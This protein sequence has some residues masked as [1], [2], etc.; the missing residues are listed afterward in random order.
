MTA[1]VNSTAYTETKDDSSLS[2]TGGLND[3]LS[4]GDD[5]LLTDSNNE[6]SLYESASDDSV[7]DDTDSSA[8]AIYSACIL[9]STI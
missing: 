8:Y 2:S 7:V 1:T 4:Y 5:L 6:S 3:K 9:D